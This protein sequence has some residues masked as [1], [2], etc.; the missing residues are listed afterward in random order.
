MAEILIVDDEGAIREGLKMT[1]SGEGFAVRT[2]RDGD[3]ALKKIG[4]H[5]PDLVLLDVMMPRMNGFAACES[6]RKE[7][8]LLPVIFLTAKDSEADQ[9]RGIG[10]GAD[11]YIS[12]DCGDA[13]MLARINRA[14]ARSSAIGESV[15]GASG[16]MIMLGAVCV[17]M[18]TFAVTEKGEEIARLTKTEADILKLLDAHRGE[19]VIQ[20][21]IITDLRGNG[22]ACEDTMLY[23][24]ICNLRRK[25]GSASSMLVNKRGVGYGLNA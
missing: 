5:K 13:M 9:V 6:I 2:A 24:H 15:R 1:L 18:K 11:D 10:L 3:D 14:L 8:K 16:A 17:D 7:D 22:F 4:E 12:K 21:D 19:L 23:V 20:D 25:L